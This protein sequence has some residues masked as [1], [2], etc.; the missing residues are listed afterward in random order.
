MGFKTYSTVPGSL[1][2]ISPRPCYD[3]SYFLFSSRITRSLNSFLAVHFPFISST[4]SRAWAFLLP[5][6]FLILRNVPL[7]CHSHHT[8]RPHMCTRT[9]IYY[10]NARPWHTHIR[11]Y[12]GFVISWIFC[13]LFAHV[14]SFRPEHCAEDKLVISPQPVIGTKYQM[15]YSVARGDIA[16]AGYF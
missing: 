13:Y 11:R 9:G 3:Y 10:M 6:A 4:P 16:R 7:F 1:G 2:Q 12:V 14:P 8:I 15:R 5:S